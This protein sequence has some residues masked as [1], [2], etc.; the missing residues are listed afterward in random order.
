MS[1]GRCEQQLDRFLETATSQNQ[2][3]LYNV[4][5]IG[6]QAFEKLTS[7][8]VNSCAAS[9]LHLIMLAK[10]LKADYQS[11]RSIELEIELGLKLP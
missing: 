1:L 10:D 8:S 4:R 5:D 7:L 9:N 11:E 6:S 3:D 2:V